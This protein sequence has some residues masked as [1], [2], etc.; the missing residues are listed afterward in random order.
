MELYKKSIIGDWKIIEG[1]R[2]YVFE[3][4]SFLGL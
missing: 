2:W 4:G 1:R 3:K